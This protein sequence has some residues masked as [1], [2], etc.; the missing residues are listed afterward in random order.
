MKISLLPFNSPNWGRFLLLL[1]LVISHF[2]LSAQWSYMDFLQYPNLNKNVTG[3][4]FFDAN[5]GVLSA[6]NFNS[7][8]DGELMWTNDGGQNWVTDTIFPNTFAH[9]RS[10]FFLTDS[11]GLVS[12]D[13]N[14]LRTTNHGQSWSN[15]LTAGGSLIMDFPSSSTGYALKKQ[16]GE[17][18]KTTDA[19]QSWTQGA[20]AFPFYSFN[21]ADSLTGILA[22]YPPG[23]T[24]S[25]PSILYRTS[26][27]GVTWDS[28]MTLSDTTS[29]GYPYF[30][31]NPQ[32][33]CLGD[34]C[35]ILDGWSSLHAR[36]F[37]GGIG[38][39]IWQDTSLFL[40]KS[41][42]RF[43]P[44]GK[45]FAGSNFMAVSS[46][47]DFGSSWSFEFSTSAT[48]ATVMNFAFRD[49][50][51]TF[52]MGDFGL[53]ESGCFPATARDVALDHPNESLNLFP[54]PANEVIGIDMHA[55][56]GNEAKLEVYNQFGQM[57]EQVYAGFLTSNEK[58]FKLNTE[59]YP[60][61]VYRMR[62]SSGGNDLFKTFV[63]AH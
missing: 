40:E 15:V 62:L 31:L 23:G 3:M 36:T 52:A 9:T 34:T 50:T 45:A 7:S 29:W 37:D 22:T 26:N 42:V 33:D 27:G 54:N 4:H 60:N 14:I 51:C 56:I 44:D 35:L 39:T 47:T 28:L 57:I 61:G 1:C 18:Y 49:S 11:I 10:L 32:M 53:L 19:G 5:H 38:W 46:S 55:E 12:A 16:N 24:S 21:F 30:F 48:P 2:S 8:A 6:N 58:H 20:N 59:N 17:M 25:N 63:I 41:Y 13:G 43:R